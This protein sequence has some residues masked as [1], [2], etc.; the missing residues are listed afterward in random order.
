MLAAQLTSQGAAAYATAKLESLLGPAQGVSEECLR[1]RL[2]HTRAWLAAASGQLP[3]LEL[4]H[5][6]PP[7]PVQQQQ[8]QQRQ[9]LPALRSGLGR[10]QARS[11][12]LLQQ[13][14]QQQRLHLLVPV[15]LHSWR[16]LVRL[17]LVQL[18]AGERKG[19]CGCCC[20]QF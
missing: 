8:Q 14:Q 18:V 15:A 17:G 7:S 12:P 16:G 5:L 6:D 19:D 3:Q 2:P 1:S 10:A 4:Q 20:F 9:E 13:P 11:Q